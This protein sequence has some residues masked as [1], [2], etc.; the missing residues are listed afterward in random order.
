MACVAWNQE[1]I[2]RRTDH[3]MKASIALE[4]DDHSIIQFDNGDG[5]IQI[6]IKLADFI[7]GENPRANLEVEVWSQ[8][9][10]FIL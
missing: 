9:Q 10:L 5:E 3:R 2:R 1:R 4:Q 8:K 6:K 7:W